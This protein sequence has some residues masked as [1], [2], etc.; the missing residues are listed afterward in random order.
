VSG[1][2]VTVRHRDS[3]GQDRVGL[4]QVEAYLRERLEA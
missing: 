3:M 2:T 1:G 4:D